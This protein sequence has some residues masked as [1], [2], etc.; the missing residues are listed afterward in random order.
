MI[1]QVWAECY[2]TNKYEDPHKAFSM[3]LEI[4]RTEAKQLCYEILYGSKFIQSY[5]ANMNEK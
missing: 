5:V 1:E 4:S 2:L 3:K